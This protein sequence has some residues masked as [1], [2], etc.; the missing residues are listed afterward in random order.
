MQNLMVGFRFVIKAQSNAC[1][2][3]VR[4]RTMESER[5]EKRTTTKAGTPFMRVQVL[6]RA[7]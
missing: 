7:A 5:G 2:S 1:V 3:E 6:T 4:S